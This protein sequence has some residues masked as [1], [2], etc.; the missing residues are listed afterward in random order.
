MRQRE[1]SGFQSLQSLQSLQSFEILQELQGLQGKI[2]L[3]M[4][5]NELRSFYFEIVLNN[6]KFIY[7]I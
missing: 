7:R 5:R 6:F 3:Q 4:F 2:Y 1:F